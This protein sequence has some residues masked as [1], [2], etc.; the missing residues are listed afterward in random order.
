[1][2]WFT[3]RESFAWAVAF[4][5]V[6][7]LYS[8]FLWRRG[9]RQDDRVNYLLVMAAFFAHTAAMLKR[10]FSF[11]RCPINNLF[12]ATMFILWTMVAAYLVVGLWR[13]FRFLG[14]FAA[15]LWMALGV[16]ALMPALDEPAALS[17]Q[18]AVRISLH[19]ALVLLA[20]GSFGLGAVAAAMYLT[21]VHDLKRHK[22]RVL[23]ALLPPI[24]R[25]ETVVGRLVLFGF[26]LLSL[27]LLIAGL[28]LKPPQGTTYRGDPKVLW[29]VLVWA[30]YLGLLVSR[31]WFAQRGRR[32]AWAAIGNFT[33]VLLTF[34]GAHLLSP[35]HN[36]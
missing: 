36:P 2:T 30:L 3:D 22:L 19:A 15:P 12:E 7:T 29:S 13:R 5:G 14:A 34:W 6:S 25:L 27:G 10:G 28:G 1:V 21:Q 32:L 18:S 26:A 31:W 17:D 16:F 33:F 35:V 8:V 24:Q 23:F 11:Q 4:Y 20:Y 9:F